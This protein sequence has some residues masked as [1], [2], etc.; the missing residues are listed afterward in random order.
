MILTFKPLRLRPEHWLAVDADRPTSPFSATYRQTLQ[1]LDHEL[2]QLDALDVHLQ[3]LAASSQIRLDGQ[4]RSDA[5]VDHPGVILTIGT[6]RHGVLVYETDRYTRRWG[7]NANPA[8]QENL[9]AIALGLEA[10]RKVERYGIARRGEQYAGY[11]ELGSGVPMPPAQMTVEQAAAFLIEHGDN[12]VVAGVAGGYTVAEL[13]D[14][15]A[16]DRIEACYR[17][18]AKHLHPDAGGDPALFVKLTE[19]R[20]LLIGAR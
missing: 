14:R 8:W 2:F 10:L 6:R 17:R 4:L 16:G 18:A 3:V 12:K 1:L 11:R 13:L 5:R 19:A 15:F 7:R 20:D 9:R